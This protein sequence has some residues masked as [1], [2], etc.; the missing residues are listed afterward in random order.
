MDIKAK[1]YA[2]KAFDNDLVA[3]PQSKETLTLKKPTYIGMGCVYQIW[4]KQIREF[5]YDYIKNK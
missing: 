1:L 4:V 5:H 2:T 3:I